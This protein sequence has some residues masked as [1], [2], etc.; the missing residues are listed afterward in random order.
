L[1]WLGAGMIYVL[2]FSWYWL[3]SKRVNVTY[4]NRIPAG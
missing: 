3:K 1:V 2:L 4:L